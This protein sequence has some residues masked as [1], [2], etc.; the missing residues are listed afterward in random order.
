MT[1]YDDLFNF[2]SDLVGKALDHI[3]DSSDIMDNVQDALHSLI[4]KF[5]DNGI[6]VD[7]S[8]KALLAANIADAINADPD[9]IASNIK[10]VSEMDFGTFSQS[11]PPEVKKVY[12][13][14]FK[15]GSHPFFGDACWNV[16]LIAAKEGS[17]RMTCGYYG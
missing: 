3:P 12:M 5:S 16:C 4:N 17:M 14:A 2:L 10:S 1:D 8:T 11:T 13:D 7:D 6:E 9:V 15:N